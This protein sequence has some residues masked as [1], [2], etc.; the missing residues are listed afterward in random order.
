[1][2]SRAWLLYDE[3]VRIALCFALLA[4]CSFKHGVNL[5]S[6]QD[7]STDDAGDALIDAPIDGSLAIDAAVDAHTCPIDFVSITG[8]QATSRYKFY[9]SLN[10]GNIVA[11][12]TASSTC[13][14]QGAYVA[15][16][17]DASEIAAFDLIVQNGSQPG[18]WVGL[19]DATVEGTW[20]TVLGAAATFLPWEMNQPNGGNAMN[21]AVGYQSQLYDVDCASALYVFIC[22][23]SQ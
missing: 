7:A 21:C 12:N 10:P 22:E 8:G 17:N 11:F 5:D 18:Y 20:V 9:D 13:T 6:V 16:P 23:C 15:I 4:A 2:W 3:A 19:T 14:N 1:M